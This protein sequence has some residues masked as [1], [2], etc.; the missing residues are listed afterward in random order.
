MFVDKLINN[1]GI[2]EFCGVSDSTLKYLINEVTN[3]G[4]Y[5]PFTNEGDAVAYAAGNN[6]SGR[7]VAVIMQNSGLTNAASPISSLTFLYKIPMIYFVGWRGHPEEVDEPQHEVIGRH[8]TDLIDDLTNY[9]KVKVSVSEVSIGYKEYNTSDKCLNDLFEEN[10]QIFLL[11]RRGTFSSVEST[12]KE[13]SVNTFRDV[14]RFSIIKEV[15]EFADKQG[16]ISIVTTTGYTSRELMSLGEDDHKNFYCVGSMGCAYPFAVGLANA[17]PDRKFI[18]IDGDGAAAM[19]LEN[20]L[21]DHPSN[22]FRVIIA[23]DEH[24]STGGQKFDSW[25]YK[26]ALV[27]GCDYISLSSLSDFKD[28]LK[29]WYT[30]ARHG[31]CAG[32]K[33]IVDVNDYVPDNLPRPKLT[34]EE[35]I[36][37]FKKGLVG[38]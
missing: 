35:I 20:S 34:P 6:L 15:K 7:R 1:A 33:V 28:C 23:N 18:V 24:Q 30:R 31:A 5:T 19:R 29:W 9:N 13:E 25:S 16:D 8:T 27:E 26:H 17:N 10:C 21:I 2:E 14:S 22:L 37:N 38:S 32:G 3:R 11:V 36:N 4:I 12:V